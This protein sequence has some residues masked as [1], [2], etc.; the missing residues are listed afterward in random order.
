M[1][2]SNFLFP[3]SQTPEGDFDVIQE[4]LKEAELTEELGY[5][6]VWL[7]EHH[8]DGGCV[9]V[10]PITFAS[11]IAARTQRIKI[12]F[13]VAQM[14][15][16][17]PIRFA[18]QIALIDNISRGRMIVGVGDIVKMGVAAIGAAD[19]RGKVAL[20]SLRLG[21]NSALTPA[22]TAAMAKRTPIA[23][24]AVFR[25]ANL[26]LRDT[27]ATSLNCLYILL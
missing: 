6:A 12:G 10:D 26:D 18:E 23:F 27:G 5:D 17:H 7:A 2:F 9:Y 14:A 19:T 15:L 25:L 8:F 11:A 1:K 22:A 4:S 13:A 24:K 20:S 3:E 16:H 21:M